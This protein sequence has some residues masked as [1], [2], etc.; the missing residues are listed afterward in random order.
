[1]R[2]ILNTCYREI[3]RKKQNYVKRREDNVDKCLRN[4]KQ[5]GDSTYFLSIFF[6]TLLNV[7]FVIPR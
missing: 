2:N 7:S 5:I 1:M 6:R 4:V 3:F